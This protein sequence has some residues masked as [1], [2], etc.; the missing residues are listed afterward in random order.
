MERADDYL[1]Q[2]LSTESITQV[3]QQFA[4]I[5]TVYPT[6]QVTAL[7]LTRNVCSSYSSYSART[8][9]ANLVLLLPL[10]NTHP[11]LIATNIENTLM[12]CSDLARVLRSVLFGSVC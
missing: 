1:S 10:T 5:A 3:R 8:V 6:E 11:L 7:I 9:I 4:Y 2:L 12:S